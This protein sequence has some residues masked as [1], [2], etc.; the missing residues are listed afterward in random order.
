MKHRSSS[1]AHRRHAT[2]VGAGIAGL[3]TAIRLARAG[4]RVTVFEK[5][6]EPGGRCGRVHGDGFHFDIGPTILLVPSVLEELFRDAGRDVHDYLNIRALSPNYRVHF[7]DGSDVTLYRERDLLAA[8]LERIE[9]GSAA[10]FNE[11]FEGARSMMDAALSRFVVNHYDSLRDFVSLGTAKDLLRARAYT[12]VSRNVAKYFRDERLQ[13]AFSYQTMY[14]GLSPYFAPG[15]Y[16]LLP[17]TE[18]NDGVFYTQGGLYEIPLALERLAREL[19]V[20]FRYGSPVARLA[21]NGHRVTEVVLESGERVA[22]DIVVANADLPYVYDTLIPEARLPRRDSLEFTS[23]G[24]MLYLGLDKQYPGLLHHNTFFGA[25]FRE[26]FR[27]IFD[28]KVLPEELHYYVAAPSVTDPSVAPPG[29]SSLYVLVPVPHQTHKINW[30]EAGDRLRAR[31]LS[32]LDQSVAPGIE[33]HITFERRIDPNG[34]AKMF[35]LVKGS[36]FGLSLTLDQV[37]PF[38]P[39]NRDAKFNNLYF[40]G[41]S[42]Q[43]GTG[44]PLVALSGRLAAERILRDESIAVE[45]RAPVRPTTDE[46]RGSTVSLSSFADAAE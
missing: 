7:A 38:R 16:G 43:P 40:A 28:D 44:I 18:I 22:A 4:V 37:G 24:F 23:S 45:L 46:R 13:M 14:L 10:R 20:E 29:G 31:V 34:W 36:A 17:F 9:P 26:S 41:A 15:I 27:E 6:S 2:V 42:T 39:K 3:A 5:N 35:N 21:T 33:S 12:T 32:A 19:G 30:A 1:P 25:R 8:E 11:F